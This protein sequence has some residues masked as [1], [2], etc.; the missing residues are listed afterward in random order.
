MKKLMF[1]ALAS[2]FVFACSKDDES[3]PDSGVK[4]G[5]VTFDIS[6]VNKLSDGITTRGPI[7]SQ[8]PVQH[9]TN[10]KVY[11]FENTG[12]AYTHV[13]TYDITGWTDGTTFKRF[14]VPV[15]DKLGEGSY[16]FLAVGRDASDKFSVTTPSSSTT[17]DDMLASVVTTG[18]EDEI[19]AGSKDVT[20][21]SEGSRVSIE[22]TRK[23]AGVMGYFKNVPQILNGTTVASLRLTASVTNK[24]VNLTT[25][26]GSSAGTTNYNIMNIDLTTQTVDNGVYQGN[27]LSA[28]GVVKL[29]NSQL[30]GAYLLPANGVTLT[31][32]LYD[33]SGNSLKTWVV[34]DSNG[35]ASTF[36][37]TGNHFYSL[38]IKTKPDSTD[39][40]TGDPGDDDSAIDLLTDQ[41]IVVSI[42]P[43]WE[44]IHNLV[45]Q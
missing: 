34:K 38:G 37:I 40:G 25:G 23:V 43:A 9:V 27:D 10:V 21:A 24:S 20:I 13:K 45:I 15:A 22:M 19:F 1:L 32:G 35:G 11:A 26:I 42:N 31:L 3:V 4:K 33:A 36:N 28:Q 12:S 16:K 18:D 39:G 7:Y 5:Y 6:A 41:N 8:A 30:G 17:F 44:T 29:P 14:E 2:L